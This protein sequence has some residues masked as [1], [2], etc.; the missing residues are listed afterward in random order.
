M[1]CRFIV[2]PLMLSSTLLNCMVG[3]KA[4]PRH[5]RLKGACGNAIRLRKSIEKRVCCPKEEA[6][7]QHFGLPEEALQFYHVH[8]DA[9]DEHGDINEAI[10]KR[11][12]VSRELQDKHGR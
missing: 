11:Y 5:T 1:C 3:S 8:S 4:W 12:C 9:N 7:R 10:L 2:I 6:L